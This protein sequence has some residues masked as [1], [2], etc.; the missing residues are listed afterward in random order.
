MPDALHDHVERIACNRDL[1]TYSEDRT[2]Q[3]ILLPIFQLLGWSIFDV[4]EVYPEYSAGRGRVDYALRVG[5]TNK[6]FVEAK[7]CS[8]DLEAHQEQLLN[9]A[10]QHGVPLAVLTNGIVWWFYLP[11]REGVWEQRKFYSIDLQQQAASDVATRLNDFLGRDGVASG[12]AARN[13]EEVLT[14]RRRRLSVE[15]TLP[16]AWASLLA[17]PDAS[18]VEVLRERVEQMAGFSPTSAEVAHFL[19]HVPDAG[20]IGLAGVEP[21]SPATGES[22]QAHTPAIE[23]S[24]QLGA[25]SYSLAQLTRR[26]VSFKK[27]ATLIVGNDRLDVH[28]WS[29][30]SVSLIR[31]LID[32]S[33]LLPTHL[34]IRTAA[35]KNRYFVNTEPVHANEDLG[36][37]WHTVGSLHVD[38]NFSAT[39]HL[40]N[41]RAVLN[42]IGQSGLD[43]RIE[44][45]QGA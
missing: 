42:Q 40:R 26:G 38:T 1:E 30:L 32:A 6:V 28:N 37:K 29:G 45:R 19:R 39:D 18:L 9:Y 41:L 5:G 31:W 3:S 44:L 7:R 36:G 34:P 2:K 11:L 8:V 21:T 20:R 12:S 23:A 13:A 25:D 43:V 14:S 35:G 17:E 4:D 27:P 16:A 24:R 15:R 10:F 22:E 33:L